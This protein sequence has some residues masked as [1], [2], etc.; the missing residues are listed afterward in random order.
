MQDQLISVGAQLAELYPLATKKI[1]F[2]LIL[3]IFEVP[4]LPDHLRLLKKVEVRVDNSRLLCLMGPVEELKHV[5]SNQ[6]VVAVNNDH[7]RVL[8]AMIDGGEVNVLKR[9]SPP[10]VFNVKKV[11]F[12]DGVEAEEVAI[13]LLAAVSGGIVDDDHFVVGI[14]L[15][16]YRVQVVF[17][18]EVDVVV[19]ARH[20]KAHRQFLLCLRQLKFGLQP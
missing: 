13:Y 1:A 9:I 3:R 18:A 6:L 2:F 7:N 5:S 10:R 20:Y 11:F 16:E 12:V 14:I 8:A 15:G 4:S 17:D 19:I